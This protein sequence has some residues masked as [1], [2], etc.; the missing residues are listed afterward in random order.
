MEMKAFYTYREEP[1]S[2]LLSSISEV[3]TSAR[4]YITQWEACNLFTRSSL[5]FIVIWIIEK[6]ATVIFSILQY[7]KEDGWPS[8]HLG[9]LFQPAFF[10]N[11]EELVRL[12]SEFFFF[13]RKFHNFF[14]KMQN[15]FSYRPIPVLSHAHIS[16]SF[17][18]SLR[19]I[20]ILSM[21]H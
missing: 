17:F 11:L 7:G 1:R 21:K 18:I 4:T 15:N 13:L 14:L 3:V 9:A 10:Y 12:I 5:F 20:I 19:I 16:H 8:D 2:C 6:L